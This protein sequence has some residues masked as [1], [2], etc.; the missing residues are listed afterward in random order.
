MPAVPCARYD[1][2]TGERPLLEDRAGGGLRPL[3]VVEAPAAALLGRS[4]AARG[5]LR[6]RRAPRGCARALADHANHAGT[7]IPDRRREH[8]SG[9]SRG[10]YAS[11]SSWQTAAGRGPRRDQSPTP[12]RAGAYASMTEALAAP[13]R[14]LLT[15]TSGP[16]TRWSRTRRARSWSTTGIRVGWYGAYDLAYFSALVADPDDRR[17]LGPG[18]PAGLR[19]GLVGSGCGAATSSATFVMVPP[20]AASFA[21][22]GC[23]RRRR[24][25]GRDAPPG[26]RRRGGG[27]G[28]GA[29]VRG[30]FCHRVVAEI[31]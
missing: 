26:A 15:A 27:A 16:R 8:E 25:L 30:L 17:R 22:C 28:W 2:L 12:R 24:G 18:A 31:E 23:C 14:T 7:R 19:V 11:R 21:W 29:A 5:R 20:R 1:A 3:A 10:R 6:R 9:P 13:P 4:T